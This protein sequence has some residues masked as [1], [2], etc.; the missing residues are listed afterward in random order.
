M[1]T[2]IC[3]YCGIELPKEKAHEYEGEYFCDDCWDK[4]FVTCERCGDTIPLDNAYRGFD[5]YLCEC[6]HDDLFG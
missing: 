6:C 4:L 2:V 3:E 5:G 1:E